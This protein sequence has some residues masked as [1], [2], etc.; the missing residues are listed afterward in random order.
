MSNLLGLEQERPVSP[1]YDNIV[2]TGPDP[3]LEARVK[4][5]ADWFYWIAGL[6]VINSIAQVTGANFHFLGGLG[7]TEVADAIIDATIKQG[8]PASLRVVSI[9]FDLVAIAG[10]AL[11]GYFA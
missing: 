6:S 9:V 4:R 1:E 7:L 8:E 11:A 3:V 2:P 5:G 10:F